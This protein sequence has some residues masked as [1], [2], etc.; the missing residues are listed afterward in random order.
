MNEQTKG[1]QVKLK[2]ELPVK[3]T[4]AEKISAAT[5]VVT[6]GIKQVGIRTQAQLMWPITEFYQRDVEL[7]AARLLACALTESL[8]AL[9][10][11]QIDKIWR[12]QDEYLSSVAEPELLDDRSRTK[13]E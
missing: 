11:Q 4:L 12:L 10:L 6:L 9:P 3:P 5:H 1:A 8:Q 13:A 7:M 2:K